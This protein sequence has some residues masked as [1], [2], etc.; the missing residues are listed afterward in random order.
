MHTFL[1]NTNRQLSGLFNEHTTAAI[2]WTKHALHVRYKPTRSPFGALTF[3]LG[4][5]KS[6]LGGSICRWASL[7]CFDLS[8]R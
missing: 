1:H 5:V 7:Q 8:N 4:F 3:L 6:L 2:Y